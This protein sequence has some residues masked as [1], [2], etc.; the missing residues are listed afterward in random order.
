[1]Q[2]GATAKS[3]SKVMP[4]YRYYCETCGFEKQKLLNPDRVSGYAEDCPSCVKP[5]APKLGRPEALG[6]ETA[7]EYRGKSIDLDLKHKLGERAG[8]HFL[9]HDLPRII[10]REGKEFAIRQG[11]LDPEGNPKK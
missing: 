3:Q 1:V 9:E 6:K 4:F 10:E 11:F 8:Q 5:L 2:R 7:D